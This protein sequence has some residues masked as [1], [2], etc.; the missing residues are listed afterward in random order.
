V[1]PRQRQRTALRAHADRRGPGGELVEAK[2]RTYG[3]NLD[4]D[5]H[6]TIKGINLFGTSLTT[7]NLAANR[8]VNPGG[9]AAASNI[10]IDG[11]TAAY[12]THFTDQT[13]NYQMQWQQKSG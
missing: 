13:G 9:V 10:L 7:D 4:G 3:F 12:V 6:I 1:V 5:S 2:R 8:N 11:M